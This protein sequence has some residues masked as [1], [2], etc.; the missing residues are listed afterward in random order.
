M[1]YTISKENFWSSIEPAIQLL[2]FRASYGSLG[3]QTIIGSRI[4]RSGQ[5]FSE[6]LDPN[7][8]NYLYLEEI[9]ISQRLG[10]LIDGERPNYASMPGIRSEN[11][12]WETIT[13][14]NLGIEAAFLENRL[15]LEADF[16]NRVTD[17]MMGP[18][19]QLPS[20]L[21]AGAPTTNNA[22][23]ETKGYEISLS[24]RDRIENFSYHAKASLGDYQAT[25]LEYVNETGNV[26]TWYAGKKHG[27]VWGLVSDGLIQSE[28]E[29]MHDQSYYYAKWG[30]GDMK[31]KDLTND[32]II[33]PGDQTLD[34]HG[35]LKIITNT[36]PRYL[37][38]LNGGFNWR[39]WDFNM[40]WQGVGS[41]PFIPQLGSEFYWGHVNNPNSAILIKNSYHLDYWRPADE[42]NILGPNTDAYF[43]KPY[44]STERNKN[45]QTQTRFVD[46]AR[47][48]R[49]KN[50]QV[51]YNLPASVLNKLPV[52]SLRI[53]FSGENLL[54]LQSL[55]KGYEPENMIASDTYMRTYPISQMYSL[56]LNISF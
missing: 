20:V 15:G 51:G 50:L 27:D 8:A 21:G 41:S 16:Y 24:W 7:V 25:I 28:N 30:P 14:M 12:T 32:G 2:K 43:P 33:D 54:T 48:L 26:H 23:L 17:N 49:L 22:K 11:L 18:S 35:D 53:Y 45:L 19:I 44:F 34:D 4:V 42:T 10:R 39:N 13:T 9:P 40:F 1:G 5:A 29:P 52:S 46:N 38:S 3:N 31:Y 36:T 6:V 47:Y 56:G 55:P 37:V